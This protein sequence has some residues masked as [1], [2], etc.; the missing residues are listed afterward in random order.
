MHGF[1]RETSRSPHTVKRSAR[2]DRFEA[3]RARFPAN[4][5]HRDA[6]QDGPLDRLDDPLDL[7]HLR[8]SL[9]RRNLFHL[10]PLSELEVLA[11]DGV[12][13]GEEG[14]VG[15]REVVVEVR[16]ERAGAE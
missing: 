15:G 1:V 6:S 4:S 16:E 3:D 8:P 2:Q 9:L 5:R 7:P 14:G 13:L 12:A 11:C 10:R